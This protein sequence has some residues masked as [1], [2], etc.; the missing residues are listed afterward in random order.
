MEGFDDG[1]ENKSNPAGV[2]GSGSIFSC[3]S[4]TIGTESLTSMRGVS[5]DFGPP[6]CSSVRILEDVALAPFRASLDEHAGLPPLLVGEA[7]SVF[8]LSEENLSVPKTFRR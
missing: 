7:G 8:V 5:T 6:F 4:S 3:L 1:E 2:S